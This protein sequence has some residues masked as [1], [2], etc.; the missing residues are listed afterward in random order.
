VKFAKAAYQTVAKTHQLTGKARCE[1]IV[2]GKEVEI[3]GEVTAEA[4][5]DLPAST[6][7]V[8]KTSGEGGLI[9]EPS[10]R[11]VQIQNSNSFQ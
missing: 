7:R 5:G 8:G 4:K 9:A 11:R 10:K 3:E 1:A 6:G 2:G